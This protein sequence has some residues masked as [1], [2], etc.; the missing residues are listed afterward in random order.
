MDEVTP[1]AAA[2]LP[3][4]AVPVGVALPEAAA[5]AAILAVAVPAPA[6]VVLAVVVLAVVVLAVVVLA[7]VVLAVVKDLAGMDRLR[8]SRSRMRPKDRDERRSPRRGN[9][10]V[11]GRPTQAGKRTGRHV[12]RRP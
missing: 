11:A 7:V 9:V 5:P 6:V 4:A 3:V 8:Q 12:R 1:G 10:L 2:S